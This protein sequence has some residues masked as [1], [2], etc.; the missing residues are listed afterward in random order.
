MEESSS[1]KGRSLSVL[2]QNVDRLGNKVD[3][4]NDLLS[5]IEPHLVV[6]TEHGLSHKKLLNTKLA[7]FDLMASYCRENTLKGGVAI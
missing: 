5:D 3:R 6:L 4:M 1:T 2:H 7:N